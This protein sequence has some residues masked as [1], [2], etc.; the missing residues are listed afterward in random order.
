MTVWWNGREWN[1]GRERE[2]KWGKG[3][4][5]I[6]FWMCQCEGWPTCI[7]CSVCPALPSRSLWDGAYMKVSD[8]IL[9]QFGALDAIGGTN[10]TDFLS[11]AKRFQ[12]LSFQGLPEPIHSFVSSTHSNQMQQ[13]LRTMMNFSR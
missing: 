4:S 5:K 9:G 12:S 8:V 10:E 2:R 3:K 7:V 6:G 1:S 13:S 11:I